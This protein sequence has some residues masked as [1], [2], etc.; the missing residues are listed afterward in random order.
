MHNSQNLD[1]FDDGSRQLHHQYNQRSDMI[2]AALWK[3]EQQII[4]GLW[5]VLSQIP[6]LHNAGKDQP[7]IS[8]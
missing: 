8:Q 4:A 3:D 5:V 2:L 1:V 7:K 6:G